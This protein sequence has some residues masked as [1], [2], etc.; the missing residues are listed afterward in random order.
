MISDVSKFYSIFHQVI[1]EKA[2]LVNILGREMCSFIK[3]KKSAN[4]LR[5]VQKSFIKISFFTDLRIA[6]RPHLLLL[7]NAQGHIIYVSQQHNCQILSVVIQLLGETHPI[8]RHG[9]EAVLIPISIH[10]NEYRRQVARRISVVKGY[11][12]ISRSFE[13]HKHCAKKNIYV[14]CHF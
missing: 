10:G 9:N 1:R 4:V 14:A 11:R 3:I 6:D 8:Y 5:S 2:S 7:N 12:R 13:R